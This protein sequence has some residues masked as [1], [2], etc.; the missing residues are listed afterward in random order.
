MVTPLSNLILKTRAHTRY[1]SKNAQ[2]NRYGF[3]SLLSFDFIYGFSMI[4]EKKKQLAI[5][6]VRLQIIYR[7][8]RQ[9]N[10]AIIVYT[11][12]QFIQNT[13]RNSL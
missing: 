4:K 12:K 9:N 1:I 13:V 2:N 8:N 3:Y 10:A 6:T 7:N 11:T 5:V